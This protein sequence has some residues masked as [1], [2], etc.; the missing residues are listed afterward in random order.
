MNTTHI[1]DV[2][3][4]TLSSGAI[5]PGVPVGPVVFVPDKTF[6]TPKSV[7]AATTVSFGLTLA[8]YTVSNVFR[9]PHQNIFWLNIS[10]NDIKTVQIHKSLRYV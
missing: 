10:V 1:E 3:R 6:A 7:R 4:A 8:I 9:Y 5:N 2:S